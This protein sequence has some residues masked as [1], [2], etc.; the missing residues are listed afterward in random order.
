LDFSPSL[1]LLS[2]ERPPFFAAGLAAGFFFDLL[3]RHLLLRPPVPDT[4]GA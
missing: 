4:A 2:P 1:P 3:R